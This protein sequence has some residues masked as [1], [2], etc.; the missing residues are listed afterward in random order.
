MITI[1]IVRELIQDL[2]A[3]YISDQRLL[4]LE[5]CAMVYR[6]TY[7]NGVFRAPQTFIVKEKKA[8][9][10][11]LS[12]L[13]R[14]GKLY[15]EHNHQFMLNHI[16]RDELLQQIDI[17]F[18]IQVH[19]SKYY[20]DEQNGYIHIYLFIIQNPEL[21][22]LLNTK[23]NSQAINQLAQKALQKLENAQKLTI[24]LGRV[25]TDQ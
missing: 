11:A 23:E 21:T 4:P 15:K 13:D 9:W 2:G 16:R 18:N 19:I 1:D 3:K 12:N 6:Q 7:T 14:W 24:Q 22:K 25:L 5:S 10:L 17:E 8:Q 20:W